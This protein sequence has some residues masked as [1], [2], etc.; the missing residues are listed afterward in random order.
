MTL[1]AVCPY[2]DGLEVNQCPKCGAQFAVKSKYSSER[3][4]NINCPLCGEIVGNARFS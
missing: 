3:F 4:L 1:C 2:E